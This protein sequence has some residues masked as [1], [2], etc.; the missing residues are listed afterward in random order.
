MTA[1]SG[2]G[3]GQGGGRGIAGRV[4]L[5]TGATGGI[6]RAM[7]AGLAERGARVLL[8]A[9][10]RARG[11]DALQE[12][13]ARAHAAG[14][15][16]SGEVLLAD[17]SR[18]ADVRRLARAVRERTAVD[19]TPRLD[20]LVNNAGALFERR[21]LTPDGVEATFALNHLAYFLLTAEL[22]APLRAAGAATGDARVV[23]VASNAHEALP[24]LPLDDLQGARR[25]TPFRAY[26]ISKLANVMFAFALARRLAD[27]GV[28]A[29]AMHPGV[30]ASGFGV[31]VTGPFGWLFRLG[32]P[33]FGTPEQGART[34]VY[35]AADP[36]T[37]GATGGYYKKMRPARS[38]PASR[39][40]A[41]QEALWAE[42]E[43]LVGAA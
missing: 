41:A 22:L 35:L 17:L 39:D 11:E 20:V 3:G 7:A 1:G 40:V 16:G 27:T 31:G 33:F 10:D 2:G 14:N 23:V 8:V 5:V 34:G 32:R 19:G 24:R 15:G 38:S 12:V 25:W 9:R 4:A 26:S 43:R 28:A 21:Q 13:T 37:R 18:Q 36:A 42:S 29:N 30:I 6:G